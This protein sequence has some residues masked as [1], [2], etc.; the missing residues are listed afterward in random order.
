VT[1]ENGDLRF[2]SFDYDKQPTVNY[3]EQFIIQVIKTSNKK[4][5]HS[6]NPDPHQRKVWGP[7]TKG[8]AEKI[9]RRAIE[10]VEFDVEHAMKRHEEKSTVQ[11]KTEIKTR[12]RSKV[13]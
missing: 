9:Y 6:A 4:A 8:L 1:S 12:R 2:H 11:N 7:S 13:L 5:L 3:V 10:V